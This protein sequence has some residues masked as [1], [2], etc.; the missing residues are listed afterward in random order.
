VKQH[1]A[2]CYGT[3]GRAWLEYL[4]IHTEG[5]AA[6][7]R[8]RMDAVEAQ[9]VPESAAGQVQR[10]GRRFALVA[11]AGELATEAGLTGWPAGEA[12]RAARACFEA[13]IQ[14]RGG[15]GSS[16]VTAMLRAVRRFL[17][18]HGEG[19]FSMW[20]R[21]ADDHAAKTLQKAGVR[22]MVGE[23]GEPIK[24]NSQ[25]GAEFGERMPASLGEGVSYEYF[26]LAET[27]K[28]EV[29][30]GFDH[31]A[32]ARVLLD[33]GCLVTKNPAATA[34]N[35]VTRHR[36]CPLATASRPRSLNLICEPA[37]RPLFSHFNFLVRY[38][39]VK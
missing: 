1:A 33:H 7:L 6:A 28:G 35:Q 8:S 3:A 16:E 39:N 11:V 34:S 18:A 29:C 14:S 24:T 15:S 30:Q 9:I 5:L 20:H 36:A 19:R 38:Q 4:V 10:G 31:Q 21:G 27:F 32:V 13:W 25:H 26:I 37:R 22:R 2:R 23:D 12:T 17:E